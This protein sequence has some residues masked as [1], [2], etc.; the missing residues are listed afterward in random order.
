MIDTQE[1]F[2][3]STPDIDNPNIERPK[4]PEELRIT[5]LPTEIT[6]LIRGKNDE[7]YTF[8]N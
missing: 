1:V 7:I 4:Q 3:L 2:K 5:E 6:A 8:P